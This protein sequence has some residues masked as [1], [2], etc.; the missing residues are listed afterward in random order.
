MTTKKRPRK[1]TAKT[2]ANADE[3][4]VAMTLRV[5]PN[6]MAHADDLADAIGVPRSSLLRMALIDG[7]NA[8]SAKYGLQPTPLRKVRRVKKKGG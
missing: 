5:P 8:L 3:K 2:G 4:Q 7:L 1:K 6:I